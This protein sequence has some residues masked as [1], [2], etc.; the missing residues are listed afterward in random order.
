MMRMLTS[1]LQDPKSLNSDMLMLW[2]WDISIEN[3]HTSGSCS[4]DDHN[5]VISSYE[6][7]TIINNAS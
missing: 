1:K 3:G 4:I 6:S 5:T 7:S 2:E